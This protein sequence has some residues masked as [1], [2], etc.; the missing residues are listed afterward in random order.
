MILHNK[1]VK[2]KNLNMGK[3]EKKKQNYIYAL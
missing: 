3:K 2:I 1:Q